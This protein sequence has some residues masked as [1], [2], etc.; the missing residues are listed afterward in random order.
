MQRLTVCV[1]EGGRVTVSGVPSTSQVALVSRSV[2]V[3]VERNGNGGCGWFDYGDV[4]VGSD[5][6]RG[7]QS[8]DVFRDV[9][10]QYDEWDRIGE[11]GGGAGIGD[12]QSEVAAVCTSAGVSA[13]AQVVAVEHVV[14]RATPLRRIAEPAPPL[15]GTK[16]RP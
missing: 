15:P 6:L 1:P 3:H 8:D 14:G 2:E 16:L 9:E 13:I 12:L 5:R 7:S 11:K 4:F 10:R